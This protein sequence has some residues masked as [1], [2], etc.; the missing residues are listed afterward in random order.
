MKKSSLISSAFIY[1]LGFMFIKA[2]GLITSPIYTRL[3]TTE[4]YGMVS[5]FFTWSSMFTLVFGLYTQG[6]LVNARIDLSNVEYKKYVS[7]CLALS[8]VGFLVCTMLIMGMTE[9]FSTATGLS[10]Y[11]L[12]LLVVHAYVS[13]IF[14][15]F[16]QKLIYENKRNKYLIFS[17]IQSVTGA[18]L[19]IVCMMYLN[20]NRVYLRVIGE[21]VPLGIMGIGILIVLI[22]QG[23]MLFNKRYWSYCLRLS[24][25]L[26]FSTL[27]NIILGQS[28]RVMLRQLV[29]AASAGIYSFSYMIADTSSF[30]R[31]GFIN[32]WTPYYMNMMNEK[33]YGDIEENGKI[34]LHLM[35]ILFTGYLLTI[36]EIAKLVSYPD[37][38]IG[39]QIISVIVLGQYLLLIADYIS[40]QVRFEKKNAIIAVITLISAIINICLNVFLLPI[41]GFVGAAFTTL[42]AFAIMV[43]SYLVVLKNK[44]YYI[45]VRITTIIFNISFITFFAVVSNLLLDYWIMRWGIG[46]CLA[47]YLFRYYLKNKEMFSKIV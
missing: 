21:I 34:F 12:I 5:I 16:L 25:P 17:L 44:N 47:I 31:F 3:L 13:A 27:S 43:V 10:N 38:W 28:D 35:C 24:V 39:I 6:S 15:F 37:Y 26:V 4:Q 30:L 1:S 36:P 19:S 18:V 23:R 32:T 7:S 33:K 29:S 22:Y 14:N 9:V 41:L 8:T 40:M 46:I 2:I 20:G 45:P 11:L 42:F